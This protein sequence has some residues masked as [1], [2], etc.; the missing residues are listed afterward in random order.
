[1]RTKKELMYE[2][3]KQAVE[4]NNLKRAEELIKIG[5]EYKCLR[6]CVENNLRIMAG[7]L[8][9]QEGLNDDNIQNCL[10]WASWNKYTELIES[11]L[12]KDINHSYR[13][14]WHP[15]GNM[16]LLDIAVENNDMYL[17]KF[18]VE[19]GVDINHQ[20]HHRGISYLVKN[21]NM[22]LITFFIELGA[23]LDGILSIAVSS[24]NIDVVEFLI[25]KG[26]SIE[27]NQI[28]QYANSKEMTE[29]LIS[30]GADVNG[31]NGI[32]QTS[33]HSFIGSN[34]SLDL[35][36]LLIDSGAN[37][38]AKDYNGVTPLHRAVDK[39]NIE[40]AKLLKD[41]GADVNAKTNAGKT[42]LK[43]INPHLK[44]SKKILKFLID[45]GANVNAKDN[46]DKTI[47]HYFANYSSAVSHIE[48]LIKHGAN[49]N[50]KDY[51]GNTPLH[52]SAYN[53][54]CST[55]RAFVDLGADVFALNKSKETPEDKTS[56]WRATSKKIKNYIQ[57]T[58]INFSIEEVERRKEKAMKEYDDMMENEKVKEKLKEKEL[59]ETEKKLMEE[60]EQMISAMYEDEA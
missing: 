38:N 13:R 37:A 7:I 34:K 29:F 21:S 54:L 51:H 41:A 10:H 59:C 50:A 55:S 43:H 1:M 18:L 45:S 35:I 14:H 49:V 36:K 30:L 6:L 8:L 32:G 20:N 22:N 28:L 4:A 53:T 52:I 39:D 42:P 27:K 11:I 3:L 9:Q 60:I 31:Q 40:L 19:L 25:E 33:L 57:N 46:D 12:K 2:M 5:A 48:L 15:T 26:V 56:R 58:V 44:N 47:L 24:N 23:K 16:T 17:I